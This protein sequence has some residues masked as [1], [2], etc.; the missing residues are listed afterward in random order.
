MDLD[1]LDLYG[2]ASEWVGTKVIGAGSDLDAPTTCDGW[3]VRTLMNHMLETQRYFVGSARGDSV[4]LSQDPP[5]LLGEHPSAD[6]DRARAETL[7]TFGAPGVIERTGP[8][9]GIAFSDQLLHGWDLAVSTGQDATMPQG[10]P[11]AAYSMIHGRFTAEQRE[12]VFKPEIA[13]SPGSPPQ[14]KLLA[15]TGRNPSEGM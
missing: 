13:I 11:E 5:N 14:A 9:L 2:D 12:G 6:F 3:T 8:A 1:L 10:L 15:Y 4:T 7:R